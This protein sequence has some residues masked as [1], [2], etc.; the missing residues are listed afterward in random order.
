MTLAL[1]SLQSAQSQIGIQEIPKGSNA[2]PDVEKYLKSVGLSKGYAWCMAFVYWNVQ[3]A[4]TKLAVSNPLKKTAGVM[5]QWN[6]TATKK[7]V[8]PSP[9]AIFIMDFSH[10]VGHTGFVEKVEGNLIHTIEGNTNA[11]GSREGYEVARRVRKISQIKGFI[12]I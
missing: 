6:H 12:Q 8:I 1:N 4:A 2:G 11:D 3:Q 10:G 5:D 7:V 9:G